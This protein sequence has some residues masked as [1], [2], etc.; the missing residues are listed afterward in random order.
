MVQLLPVV[1][2]G[3]AE[4][5]SHVS[6]SIFIFF[7]FLGQFY[8]DDVGFSDHKRTCLLF[9]VSIMVALI[10][11]L[12]F[13]VFFGSFSLILK[14]SGFLRPGLW[15]LGYGIFHWRRL[16]IGFCSGTVITLG[17]ILINITGIEAGLETGFC[18]NVKRFFEYLIKSLKL[19]TALFHFYSHWGF[20]I[21]LKVPNDCAFFKGSVWG[22][23]YQCWL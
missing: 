14:S 4:I 8:L 9:L 2:L 17:T 5:T 22:E 23:F 13:A 18:L 12:L 7:L 10:P 6:A 19:S 20:Q 16:S 3:L 15:F 11:L 1:G 21:F